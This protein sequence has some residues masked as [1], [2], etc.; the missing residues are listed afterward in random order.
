MKR[1]IILPGNGC[2]GDVHEVNF[3][4][5]LFRRLLEEGFTDVILKSMPDPVKARESIWIP[6]VEELVGNEGNRTILIGHSSGAQCT[7]RYLENHR[8][9][10]AV[11]VS[12]CYTDLGQKSERDAGYYNR[13]WQWEQIRRN[14]SPA[15]GIV[16]FHSS[17]DPFIPMEEAEH[18]AKNLVTER[19]FFKD[20]SHFFDPDFE[21]LVTVLKLRLRSS[22]GIS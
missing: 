20:R 15:F 10:G 12:A 8:L 7:M 21:E 4:G 16:Q 14:V 19:H 9:Y 1:I 5:T 11:L 3:Y 2:T 18:V 22:L 6:F 13:P 17:D